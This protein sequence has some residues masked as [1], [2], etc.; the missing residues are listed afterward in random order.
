MFNCPAG[1]FPA[2]Q[3]LFIQ[4][5]S[6]QTFVEIK[7]SYLSRIRVMVFLMP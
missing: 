7:Q 2:G 5:L 4:L 1:I 6:A 3:L